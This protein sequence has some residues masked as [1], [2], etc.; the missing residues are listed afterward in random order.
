[1]RHLRRI[2]RKQKLFRKNK[3]VLSRE[4]LNSV[5]EELKE[6]GSSYGYRFIHQK[7]RMKGLSTNRELVRLALKALD[8]EEVKN[9]SLKKFT[10]RKYTSAGPNYMWHT[11]GY[12]KL[13]PFG[14]A[15]HGDI[16]GYS[17]KILWLHIGSSNNNPRVIASYY[18]DCVSKLNNVIP[19]IVRSDRGTENVVLVGIQKYFRHNDT[20]QFAGR[21][22]FRYG[23]S[24]ANQRIEAWWSQL[25]RHR[26][27][28]WIIFFKDMTALGI[29]DANSEIHLQCIRFCFLPILQRELN[30]TVVLWNNHYIR[31][32]KNGECIPGRPDVLYYTPTT[33]EGRD[34]KLSVN[35][36]D[37]TAAY[38]LCEKLP[39]LGCSDEFLQLATLIMRDSNLSIPLTAQKGK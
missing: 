31:A 4:I 34:C 6:S 25:R 1:M 36:A 30:D 28:W 35:S 18:L 5:A 39:Y 26:A 32:T 24:T 29:F 2:L 3:T 12:D 16:D 17:R 22:S 20:D 23:T 19:M 10:R 27:N 15:I 13:K 9:R 21:N 37:V 14:F 38:S 7:C 33:S 8:P 11:D